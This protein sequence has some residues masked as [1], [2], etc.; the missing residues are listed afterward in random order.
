MFAANMK[1]KGTKEQK[2]AKVDDIL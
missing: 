2:S 1:M